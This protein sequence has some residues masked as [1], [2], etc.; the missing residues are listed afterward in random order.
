MRELRRGEERMEKN[1]R[2]EIFE[3]IMDIFLDYL[4]K[5]KGLAE[6]DAEILNMTTDYVGKKMMGE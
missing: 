3:E 4:I 1:K 2:K 5:E 6:D